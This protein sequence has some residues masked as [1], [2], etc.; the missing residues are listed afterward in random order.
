MLKALIGVILASLATVAVQAAGWENQSMDV[1]PGAFVGARVQLPLGGKVQARPRA[2]LTVAP[3]QS[4]ISDDGM[5]RTRIGEGLALNFG[6]DP[7]P[8]LT[9]AGIRADTALR[10]QVTARNG[11]G[12]STGGW[13]AIGVGTVVVAGAIGLALF[14]DAVNDNSE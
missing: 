6:G 4:R 10:N 11:S 2:A 8:S 7:K 12:I 14:V 13:I 1:R 5:I 9:V 3:T